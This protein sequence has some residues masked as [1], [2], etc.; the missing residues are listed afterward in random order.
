MIQSIRNFL[1]TR[2]IQPL[3]IPLLII[4]GAIVGIGMVTLY[5]ASYDSPERIAEA[6]RNLGLA[7]LVMMIVANIPSETL[8]RYSLPAYIAVVALLVAVAL[9]GEIRKGAQRWL[10]IGIMSFQ[11]AE[12]MKIV[13]PLTLAWYFG[14]YE[15]ALTLKN[16]VVAAI[17]LMIP[18]A[19]IA[20]QPD[21]GTAI[22]VAGAGFSVLF[23][24]G[25]SWRIMGVLAVLGVLC[26][27]VIWMNLF[28]YQRQRILTLLDPTSDPLGAGYHI[29]Q[30]MIA[31]GSGGVFGKGWLQG[32]QTHLE[33]LPES[34]TDFIFAVYAEEFGLLG[35]TILVLCYFM[36]I[37]RAFIIAGKAKTGSARLLAG[38]IG[39]IFFMYAFVNIGMV[40]GILPVVGVPL[41]FISYGG[42][43]MVT[44]FV[45]VGLLMSVQQ[46]KKLVLT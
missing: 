37:V 29:I 32:T 40:A 23:F 20:K 33:F 46:Q 1:N 25:L 4:L 43:A 15:S 39:V 42:T 9:F 41:P 26:I 35:A 8:F 2:L 14:K 27:P 17:I 31:L 30:S 6:I 36:L 34:H 45:G 7:V 21:L 24:A 44:L 16:F 3:D 22:L 19:L 18:V 5:S 10:N 11:P 28:E 13:M 12:L 38:S